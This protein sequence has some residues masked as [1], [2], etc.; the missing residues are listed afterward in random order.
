MTKTRSRL[1]YSKCDLLQ[2][3]DMP[4]DAC[5]YFDECIDCKS[6]LRLKDKDCCVSCSY[7]DTISPSG[8]LQV[9]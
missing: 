2:E 4:T 5:Q 3:V 7:A 6:V 1:T 9:I 8:Q